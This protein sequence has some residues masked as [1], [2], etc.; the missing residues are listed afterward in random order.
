MYQKPK[1][2]TIVLHFSNRKSPKETTIQPLE[3]QFTLLP[4][5]VI[6]Y[7]GAGQPARPKPQAEASGGEKASRGARGSLVYERVMVR[8]GGSVLCH[9]LCL[10]SQVY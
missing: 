1:V 5:R 4:L 7:P 10:L 6:A 3:G 8:V 9:V 2:N